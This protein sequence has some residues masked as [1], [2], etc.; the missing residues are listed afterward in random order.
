MKIRIVIQQ[1][2][3]ISIF[4]DDGSFADGAK[5]INAIFAALQAQGVKIEKQT[6][7]EQHRHE[8]G[9]NGVLAEGDRNVL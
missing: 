2:G 4:T 1:D 3:G 7:P 9:E 5:N 8:H 6:A